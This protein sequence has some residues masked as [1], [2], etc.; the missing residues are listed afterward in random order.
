MTVTSTNAGNMNQ[1]V[2]RL[3]ESGV[4]DD[5]DYNSVPII[6]IGSVVKVCIC[7]YVCM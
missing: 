5:T 3:D 2:K 1:L 4:D 6:L 7:V